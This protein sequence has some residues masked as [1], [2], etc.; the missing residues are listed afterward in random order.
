MRQEEFNAR[1]L[2]LL[3]I[4]FDQDGNSMAYLLNLK[5]NEE[6]RLKENDVFEM[7]TVNAIERTNLVLE[8]GGRLI[9]KS[10]IEQ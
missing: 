7:W 1:D 5:T 9:S 3:G 8:Q 6:Y 2:I 10:L 4:V